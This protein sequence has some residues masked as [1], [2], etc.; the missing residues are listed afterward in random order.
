MPYDPRLITVLRAVRDMGGDLHTGEIGD[1][2]RDVTGDVPNATNPLLPHWQQGVL[3]E[4]LLAQR[5][6]MLANSR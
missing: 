5:R 4:G 3:T 6:E 1:V 2:I